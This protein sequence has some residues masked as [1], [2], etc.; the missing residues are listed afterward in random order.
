M[1]WN[2]PPEPE[3]AVQHLGGKMFDAYNRARALNH[4]PR[5]VWVPE[6]F[7]YADVAAGFV[8]EVMAVSRRKRRRLLGGR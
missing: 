3:N 6:V 4:A 1:A 5:Y 8:R 2:D 7:R